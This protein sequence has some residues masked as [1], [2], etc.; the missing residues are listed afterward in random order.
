MTNIKDE[1]D[2]FNNDQAKDKPIVLKNQRKRKMP[3]EEVKQQE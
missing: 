2:F 3:Q 1:H